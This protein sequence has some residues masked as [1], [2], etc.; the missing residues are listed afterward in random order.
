M[1]C[2]VILERVLMSWSNAQI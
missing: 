1:T 2:K